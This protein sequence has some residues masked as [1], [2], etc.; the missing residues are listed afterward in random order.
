VHD[1]LYVRALVLE[2]GGQAALILCDLC[3]L[4]AAVVEC[5]RRRV[6][7]GT[8]IPAASVLVAATHTHAAPATFGLYS[9]PPDAP[10]LERFER[11]AAAAAVEA[12]ENLAPATSAV[13][14]GQEAS[15]ARNRRHPDGPIDPTVTMVRCERTA[16]GP[17]SLI[18]Y[19][20]HPTVLGPD[21]LLISRDYPGFAV[22]AVERVTGGWSA[23]ANGACGDINAGHSAG[24][25][26]LGLPMP[27]RTFERAEALGLRLAIE[28]IRALRDARPVEGVVAARRRTVTVPLRT[29]SEGQARSQTTAW[30]R[31]VDALESSG[32][33]ENALA[34]ARLEL[35]YAEAALEWAACRPERFEAAEVQAIA[36]GK[37]AFVALPGEFFAES[38]LRLRGRSP[39]HHTLVI[40]YANGGLGYVPP[41]TAF[42][43]GGYETRLSSWSRAAP[44]AEA[45]ILEAALA[46]LEELRAAVAI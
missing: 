8:G 37:L 42:E 19:A 36:A 6:E 44:G 7:Q 39:F 34:E 17:V 18:H 21:N 29:I 46:V 38:G 22:D 40:G 9:R 1:D 23:F 27:G 11:A 30:R 28:G 25:T 4:D 3:E 10:W 31:R 13:A 20:C 24:R 43:E 35:F 14:R 41:T 15:I 33:D 26:A 12:C 5:V 16:G 45:M 32:A 2:G